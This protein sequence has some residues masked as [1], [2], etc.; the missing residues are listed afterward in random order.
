MTWFEE[1]LH[2]ID[3]SGYTQRFEVARVVCE[4][5]SE[6]QELVI[7]ETPAFG[8]VLA[9]DGVIQ[10]TERDEFA[11]HEMLAHVPLFAHG[12]ARRV[13][14]IGGGDGGVLREVL[15][16]RTVERATLVEV[17]R[18]VIDLCR[19][20]MPGLSGGSFD[21][22]R[23]ELV[24]ADGVAYVARDGPPFDAIIVDS[25]DPVGPGESLYTGAFYAGCKGRLA[26]GGV[27]VT[28]NGVPFFQAD[29][30]TG[31]WRNLRRLFADAGF[32]LTV[33][34]TYSGGLMTLGWAT[35]DVALRRLP[36]A[37]LD[38]RFAAAG[39]E[40]RYYTPAVHVAAFALPPF[41]A[42]LDT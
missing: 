2:L 42:A 10:T 39:I 34:P 33:V 20:H 36:E 41:I 1:R 38:E 27:L 15:R 37:A 3:G 23:S 14:I 29:E 6:F 4:K 28:Q 18:A 19:E 21:D 22:A 25:T 5:A 40:T 9:L 24:I 12:V 7:F 16:H 35:D 8:R 13:L 17:D 31:T 26:P 11:Y 32:Y 30:V